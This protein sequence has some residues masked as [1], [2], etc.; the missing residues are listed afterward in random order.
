[1]F[2]DDVQFRVAANT[3]LGNHIVSSA[4]NVVIDTYVLM[5]QCMAMVIKDEYVLINVV[6]V[7]MRSNAA[8]SSLAKAV[9]T[10]EPV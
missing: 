2:P 6:R 10:P 8:T 7:L 9:M 4:A 5:P 1:M 3:A